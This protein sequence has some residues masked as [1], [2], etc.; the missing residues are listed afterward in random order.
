MEEKSEV[1]PVS[2]LESVWTRE[3]P[4]TVTVL[5]RPGTVLSD[6]FITVSAAGYEGEEIPYD[7]MIIDVEALTPMQL[8]EIISTNPLNMRAVEDLRSGYK[9]I[10]ST[11]EPGMLIRTSYPPALTTE[12]GFF[13]QESNRYAQ[14]AYRIAM[15][16]A[17]TERDLNKTIRTF[18]Q[19]VSEHKEFVHQAELA[20]QQRQQEE[21]RLFLVKLTKPIV[22]GKYNPTKAIA[23]L[24]ER[25]PQ[26]GE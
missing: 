18:Q 23:W 3:N 16:G 9:P 15:V 24:K 8:E 13:C 4:T 21:R 22:L 10:T 26:E 11:L 19:N 12:G 14:A 20:E 6:G 7:V 25:F 17:L 2:E 1:V 5:W